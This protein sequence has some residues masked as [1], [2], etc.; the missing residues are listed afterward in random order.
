LRVGGGGVLLAI[1][2][3]SWARILRSCRDCEWAA[4]AVEEVGGGATGGQDWLSAGRSRRCLREGARE[5]GFHFVDWLEFWYQL[6]ILTNERS[7]SIA[8]EDTV[9]TWYKTEKERPDETRCLQSQQQRHRLLLAFAA[10]N[11]QDNFSCLWAWGG[12][13]SP[14]SLGLFWHMSMHTAL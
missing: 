8:N 2:R 6:D 11:F 12:A 7:E 10:S 14:A 9:G 4:C 1:V 13:G 3:S 5:E